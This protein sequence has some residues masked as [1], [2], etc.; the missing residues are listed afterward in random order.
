MKKILVKIVEWKSRL[1]VDVLFSLLEAVLVL[2]LSNLYLIMLTIHHG[3]ETAGVTID[4]A[5]DYVVNTTLGPTEIIIYVTGLLSSTTAYFA[6]RL[7][8]EKNRLKYRRVYF[9]L[10]GTAILFWFSIPLFISVPQGVAINL[11]FAFGMAKVVGL[12]ALF[13]W[14]FSLFCQR[15]IFDRDIVLGG[16]SRADVIVENV[17]NMR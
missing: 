15:R 9:I 6:I 13:I 4:E 2:I 8:V 1:L 12:A 5:L 16:K 11:P 17:G 10:L 14:F 7:F 3:L